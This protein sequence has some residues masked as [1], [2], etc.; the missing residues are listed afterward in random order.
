MLAFT[1]HTF[2]LASLSA[3]DSSAYDFSN[4]FNYLQAP[5]PGVALRPHPI[6]VQEQTYLA[7]HP[8]NPNDPT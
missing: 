3:F 7:A 4:A 6:S 1:E 5:L 8:P 2:G